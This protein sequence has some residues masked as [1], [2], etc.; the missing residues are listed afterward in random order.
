MSPLSTRAPL[1]TRV[2]SGG[3]TT[4]L[5]MAPPV[6]VQVTAVLAVPVTEAVKVWV[7]PVARVAVAGLTETATVGAGVELVTVTVAEAD[8]VGST[9]EVAF[10][11][12]HSGGKFEKEKDSAYKFAGGLHGAGASVVGALVRAYSYELSIIAV[13]SDREL[14]ADAA[15][16]DDVVDAASALACMQ[17]NSSVI[18]RPVVDWGDGRVT[19]GFGEDRFAQLLAGGRA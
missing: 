6:V 13:R 8:F 14:P 17:A 11:V 7:A 1:S 5:V 12:L 19:V 16:W 10:T 15:R 3:C 2:P 9:V 18:K 4:P